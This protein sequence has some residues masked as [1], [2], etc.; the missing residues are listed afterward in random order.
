M[1]ANYDLLLIVNLLLKSDLFEC[2]EDIHR[3][4]SVR[5]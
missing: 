2:K 3:L 4:F 5:I 1:S